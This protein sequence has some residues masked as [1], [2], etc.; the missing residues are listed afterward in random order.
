MESEKEQEKLWSLEPQ[1]SSSNNND[2]YENVGIPSPSN[3]SSNT[4]K[5][6]KAGL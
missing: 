4:P 1:N 2:Q 5:T 6:D 3:V